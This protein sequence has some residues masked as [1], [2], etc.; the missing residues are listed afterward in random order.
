MLNKTSAI[1]V[2]MIK[3]YN[4]LPKETVEEDDD[5]EKEIKKMMIKKMTILK[6]K[7]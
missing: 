5:K 6:M 3:A 4:N 7:S 1:P 2:G